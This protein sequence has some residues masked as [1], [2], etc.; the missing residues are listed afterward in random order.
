MA[1]IP[2]CAASL[3]EYAML[4]ATVVSINQN[5]NLLPVNLKHS[6]LAK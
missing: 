1:C 4:L 6:H 2:L 5:Q 3:E